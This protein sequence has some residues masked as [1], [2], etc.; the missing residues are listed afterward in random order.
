MEKVITTVSQAY[1]L[2]LKQKTFNLQG[3]FKL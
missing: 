2:I 1:S 3:R